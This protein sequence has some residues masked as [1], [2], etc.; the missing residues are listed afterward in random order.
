MNENNYEV[1]ESQVPEGGGLGKDPSELVLAYLCCPQDAANAF[2]G[3][4]MITDY[5]TR[6]LHY[7]FVQPIRPTSY[8]KILFGSMLEEHV[9]V[10]VISNRLL[11][12]LPYVPDILFVDSQ[13]LTNVRRICEIP[14]AFLAFDPNADHN[15]DRLTTLHYDAGHNQAHESFVGSV[16]ASLE[17]YVDLV[18]PFT[19]MREALK[20]AIKSA[21]A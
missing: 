2:L 11:K 4:L 15:P 17:R 6:P 20:E 13:E 1:P 21:E 10:D 9:K 14:T 3:A 5:H 16:L 7:S 12:D 8:Q 19:R 18:D